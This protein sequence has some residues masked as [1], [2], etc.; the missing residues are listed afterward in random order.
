MRNFFTSKS[1]VLGVI[2][3]LLGLL[4]HACSDPQTV[5]VPDNEPTPY[6]GISTLKIEA[7]LS[8][9][10]IDLQGRVPTAEELA[11][12]VA[13]LRTQNLGEQA[14]RTLAERLV[15]GSDSLA[16][17]APPKQLY[18]LQIYEAMKTRFLESVSANEILEE[19]VV[20]SNAA[21]M[22]SLAGNWEGYQIKKARVQRMADLLNLGEQFEEGEIDIRDMSA[23]MVYNDIYDIINM[24]SINFIRACYDNL[25]W[26]YPTEVEFDIAFPIVEYGQPGQLLGGTA[27]DKASFVELVVNSRECSE[28]TIIW[29]FQALLARSPSTEEINHF[30]ESFH[31][32]PDLRQLQIALITTD[33][34]AQF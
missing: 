15:Y 32:Q 8:R 3:C 17:G 11:D 1:I 5:V 22:D 16:G 31:N 9:M 30:I 26:R 27:T 20:V 28:G 21:E 25:F 14:R 10:Y 12:D 6:D 24:N 18:A 2:C 4:S 23:A 34:Y 19:I 7:Y 13:M 29:A 33:E